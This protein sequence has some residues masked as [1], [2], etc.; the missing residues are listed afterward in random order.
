MRRLINILPV[1]AIAVLLLAG[2]SSCKKDDKVYTPPEQ[3]NFINNTSGTYFVTGPTIDYVIPV[4]VT[5]V[6]DHERTITIAVSSPTGAVEGTQYTLTK[7][8]IKIPAGK[9]F[10]SS[11]VLQGKFDVYKDDARR[12]TLIFTITGE[13]VPASSYNNQFV[14]LMR[15]PC[16]DY[17]VEDLNIMSGDYA[18]TYEDGGS[19]GPYSSSITNVQTLTATTGTAKINKLYESYSGVTINFDWSN[20][21]DVKVTIPYQQT[22]KLYAAGQPIWVRSTPGSTNT[23]SVCTQT[24][25]LHIDIIVRIAATGAVLG[26]LAQDYDITMAR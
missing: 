21:D 11:M 12:D 15:G 14:L 24:L 7:K 3:A 2:A 25:T 9:V 5:T 16:Q 1:C 26:A 13:G 17:E 23:F 10:D 6:A 8:S 22:D 18:R 4:A 20:P 19:Y